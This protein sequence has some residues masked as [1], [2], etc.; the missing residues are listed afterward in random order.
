VIGLIVIVVL[1]LALLRRRDRA[2]FADRAVPRRRSWRRRL[3]GWRLLALSALGTDD[4]RPRHALAPD[5][6]RALSLF[7]GA[8]VVTS[9]RWRRRAA[10][11]DRRLFPRRI[12]DVAIM[13]LMDIIW[14]CPACC[15]PSSS[16][17]SSGRPAKR[18]VAVAIVYAAALRPP[19]ARRGAGEMGRTMSSRR[20]SPAPAPCG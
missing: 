4:H 11:P 14:R 2:A 6:R 12:V 18:D 13:R 10:R 19:D 1:L 8:A 9:L 16:S 5:L 20:A 15:W 7:I 3:A 17:P